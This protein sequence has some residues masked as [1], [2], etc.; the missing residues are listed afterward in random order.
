MHF[1]R[2]FSYPRDL[3]VHDRVRSHHISQIICA[4]TAFGVLIFGA[5]VAGAPA[6]TAQAAPNAQACAGNRLVNPSFEGGWRKTEG[7]GTSLSSAVSDGWRPWFVRGDATWNREPEFK[8]VIPGLNGDGYRVRSGQSMKWFTTWG[9]HTAGMYQTVG[10]PAGAVVTFSAW[11]MIYSGEDDGHRPDLNTFVSDPLKP[12]NYRI[13][14]GIDPTGAGTP[15]GSHPPGSVV[16]SEPS[17]VTDQFVN[18]TVSARATGGAVTAYVK[19]WAEFPVKHNDS[20][21]DDA[22]LVVGGSVAAPQP[23]PGE[24]EPGA[25]AETEG[26]GGDEASGGATD[27]ASS[28][29]S[30]NAGAA[31]TGS[32]D[33]T[34]P[35]APIKRIMR[36][37]RGHWA[38][39]R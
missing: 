29:G 6:P 4:V 35:R 23:A 26:S 17:M 14:V 20:F 19:G 12:G 5:A 3:S 31:S 27:G 32:S 30:A 10:V 13:A 2:K 1:S 39:P 34:A 36:F 37:T 7:E 15:I 11:G 16:W 21:W 28:T 24:P 18:P 38:L 22:C 25:P 8:V 33:V 9:T